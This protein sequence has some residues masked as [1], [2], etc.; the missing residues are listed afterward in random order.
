MPDLHPDGRRISPRHLRSALPLLVALS[1]LLATG[2]YALDFGPHW[3]ED[4]AW[5][6][7]LERSFR[8]GKPL[9]GKYN[10][11]S[12]GYWLTLLATLP[13]VIG[14][15]IGGHDVSDHVIPQIYEQPFR[16]RLRA[17]FMIVSSLALVWMYALVLRWRGSRAEALLAACLLGF[18]W[19]F[20]YHARWIAPD[21]L[22]VQ[23]AALTLMALFFAVHAADGRRWL[24]VAAVAAG[25][26]C[27]TKYPGGLLLAPLG[28]ATLMVT[29]RLGSGA[30][31]QTRA[32][33]L[34]KTSA[35][36]LA[37]FAGLFLVTTPGV[38]FE[39]PMFRANV[40]Y[41]V[42]HYRVYGHVPHT[43][44]KGVGHAM[45][46][47]TYFGNH[48]L[49]P[50]SVL[51][52]IGTTLAA[53]GVYA[54]GRERPALA[55]M[56]LIFP[57]LHIAYM[58]TMVVFIVRNVIVDAPFFVLLA[59]RGASFIHGKLPSGAARLGFAGVGVALLAA[60]ALFLG[61][62]AERTRHRSLDR[63][64]EEL[65]EHVAA[66]PD[67]VFS[68]SPSVREGLERIGALD[69]LANVALPAEDHTH[70]ATLAI[71]CGSAIMTWQIG[72][73]GI[74]WFGPYEINFEYY[75]TAWS[76][77]QRVLVV[78]LAAAK[79]HQLPGHLPLTPP[80]GD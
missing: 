62:A 53:V 77:E 5:L 78:P 18:S 2:F 73:H 79:L 38:L 3:D 26:G 20:A 15:W 57:V 55:A 63:S 12:F 80:S 49:S 59:C 21:A 75:P 61:W 40:D 33:Q 71:E 17:I 70:F 58:S 16:L 6:E 19:E 29:S 32:L 9:P 22:L 64:L 74:E 4:K 65:A 37:L 42:E 47:L 10:Y 25:L 54:I 14:A 67:E 41:E 11:P 24:Y 45:R 46:M 30:S 1:W 56:V 44:E 76:Y 28:V 66:S 60:N 52:W 50:W 68:L 36:I 35:I 72:P 39:Y 34:V 7:P 48:F 51:A 43:V 69:G 8:E 23:F 27:G 31:L 13:E